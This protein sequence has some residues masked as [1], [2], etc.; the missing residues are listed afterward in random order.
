MGQEKRNFQN[1]LKILLRKNGYNVEQIS[2]ETGIPVAKIGHYKT[3][4][5]T[6]KNDFINKFVSGFNLSSQE[7]NEITMAIAIDRTPEVIKDNIL[8]LKNVKPIKLMEV[9]LFSSV[10]AGLG[11]ETIAEPIDFISNTKDS[12]K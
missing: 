7:K 12:W 1:I 2:R 11:R 4:R 3:G 8:E 9:P 6:P 10:S 5:R